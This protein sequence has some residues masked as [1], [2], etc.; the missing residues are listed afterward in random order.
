MFSNIFPTGMAGSKPF[1]TVKYKS[2]VCLDFFLTISY[3][4]RLTHEIRHNSCFITEV[5]LTIL[6][7]F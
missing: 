1:S 7:S 2:E 6:K 4:K 5:F 3:F